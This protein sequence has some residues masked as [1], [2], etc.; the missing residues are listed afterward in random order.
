MSILSINQLALQLV[1]LDFSNGHNPNNAGPTKTSRALAIIHL[2]ARDAYAQVTS[3]YP[4]K[5]PGLPAPPS[6][7][8][9]NDA[10]GL[11]AAIGAGLRSAMLL[12]SDFTAFINTQSGFITG[13]A[14]P[15][16]MAYGAQ[17]AEKW[18]ASR[19]SDGA[20]LPQTDSMYSKEPGHYRPDPISQAPALGRTWGD[21]TPFIIGSVPAD[22]PLAPPPALSSAAYAQ[23]FDDVFVNGRDNIAQRSAKYQQHGTVGIFWAYDGSNKL[24]TPPR[25]YN[26]MVTASADF[27]CLNNKDQINVLAAINS[28]MA[29]AGIAAWYWKYAYDFWRPVTAIREAESGWGPTGKGDGNT[30]RKHKGDPFWTPLGAPKSN[31]LSLP[32]YNFTPNFPAYPSGHATFGTACFETFAGLLCKPTDQVTVTFVSDE[33]NWTSDNSAAPDGTTDNRG[34]MRPR[35]QQTF[36]LKQAIEQNKIS[37]IYLGVHWS[38]DADGGEQVGAAIAAKA[39]AAFK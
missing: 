29:D 4:A 30:L 14:N 21:V 19:A 27:A 11:A 38:F 13:G 34:V 25:L 20:S 22:A 1:A 28:A 5:L 15:A 36:T 18:F 6:A 35:W 10:S 8:P 26:Q 31:P 7:L 23:S 33:F 9:T 24:G 39:I 16:A 32:A 3:A 17:V 37:R 12:Y 2:A